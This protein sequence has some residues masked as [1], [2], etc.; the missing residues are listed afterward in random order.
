MAVI[1]ND[2]FF[3]AAFFDAG[4]IRVGVVHSDDI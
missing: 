4:E 2:G 3:H 1:Y